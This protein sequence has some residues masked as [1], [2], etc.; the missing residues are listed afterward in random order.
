MTALTGTLLLALAAAL[1]VG[2]AELF[3]ENVAGAASRMGLTVLA[4]GVLLAGAEPEEAVTSMI[5]SGSGRPGLAVGDALGA[6]VTLLLLALGLAAVLHGV[7]VRRR[8]RLYAG[9]ASLAGF[10]ALAALADGVVTRVEG[11][12]LVAVYVGVV[13]GVWRLERTA[14]VFGEMAELDDEETPSGGHA[15]SGLLLALVGLGLMTAGGVAA[16]NG[17]ERVVEALG[18]G[19]TAV[20]LTVLALATSA[21]LLA[22]VWAAGRRRLAEVAVAGVVGSVVY[23]ATVSLGAGALVA[24]LR[25]TDARP[26]ALLAA[27]LPLVV[28]LLSVRGS[29][30]RPAG[31]ILVVGYVGYVAVLLA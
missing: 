26:A 28:L 30:A 27:V 31:A 2:G 7:P 12:L 1:L 4:V 10:L 24:P 3:A 8:V 13:A 29:L 21:E 22:L 6:N 23:N 16:V 9:A 19:D 20:G 11:G 14:P 18:V 25:V 5:A 15:T 17:A